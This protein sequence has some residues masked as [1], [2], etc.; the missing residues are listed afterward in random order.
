MR[1]LK[2][3][4]LCFFGP[5]LKRNFYE[6]PGLEVRIIIFCDDVA[7]WHCSMP[8][9]GK[10]YIPNTIERYSDRMISWVSEYLLVVNMNNM[11][12]I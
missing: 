6:G 4:W 8:L 9:Q 12:V 10:P 11:V 5:R 3:I 7:W 1:V 2:L